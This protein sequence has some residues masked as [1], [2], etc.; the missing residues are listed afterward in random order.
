MRIMRVSRMN[1]EIVEED[2][3]PAD[4][5]TYLQ[6]SHKDVDAAWDY[7]MT[8]GK[9]NTVFWIFELQMGESKHEALN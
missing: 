5:R 9:V 2:T 4:V 7:L 3:S 8:T 6:G 1:G